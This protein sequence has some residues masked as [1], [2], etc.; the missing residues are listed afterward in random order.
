MT[1]RQLIVGFDA[2]AQAGSAVVLQNFCRITPPNWQPWLRQGG[3]W[4]TIEFRAMDGTPGAIFD[5]SSLRT[6]R[7][8]RSARGQSGLELG[9]DLNYDQTSTEYSSWTNKLAK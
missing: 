2:E 3:T 4:F 7:A 1:P 6:P 8:G 9:A 5:A